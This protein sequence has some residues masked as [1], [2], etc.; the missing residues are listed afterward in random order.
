M[1]NDNITLYDQEDDVDTETA[2]YDL[3][4]DTELEET[5]TTKDILS[6]IRNT[7]KI[8]N[9]QIMSANTFVGSLLASTWDMPEEDAG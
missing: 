3:Y 4:N 2:N 6:S 9:D 7:Q 8:N 1:I 5:T